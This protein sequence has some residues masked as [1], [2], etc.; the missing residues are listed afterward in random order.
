MRRDSHDFSAVS[1][2]AVL[3][4]TLSKS[5]R[6]FSKTGDLSERGAKAASQGAQLLQRILDGSAL[7]QGRAARGGL[8]P[9]AP[10]ERKAGASEAFREYALALHAIVRSRM[11][12]ADSTRLLTTY[13]DHLVA[14]SKGTRLPKA[15]TDELLRFIKHLNSLFFA[16]LHRPTTSVYRDRL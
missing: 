5:I 3:T 7:V 6:T 14:V 13:K 10:A 1:R 15:Q 8:A 4:A 9:N 2:N 12:P 16:E 11:R